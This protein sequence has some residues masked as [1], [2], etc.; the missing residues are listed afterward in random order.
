MEALD[1]LA[2]CNSNYFYLPYE[3]SDIICIMISW[4][5][6]KSF[7]I[8]YND[9]SQTLKYFHQYRYNEIFTDGK[10]TKNMTAIAFHQEGILSTKFNHWQQVIVTFKRIYYIFIY[11]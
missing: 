7:K 11:L 6:V 2:I 10:V 8:N 5:V 1:K 9:K 3:R 4:D